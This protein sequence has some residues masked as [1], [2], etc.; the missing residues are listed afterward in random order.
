MKTPSDTSPEIE[1][2]IIEGYR[3]MPVWEKLRQVLE[4]N[5]LVQQLALNDIRRRYPD[6]DERELRLRLASRWIEP[7][8]MRRAFGWDP[9][10]E[11]Y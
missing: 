1:R 11:G 3:K 2:I 6:A 10:K 9:E 5:Q 4:L 8:L 7:E